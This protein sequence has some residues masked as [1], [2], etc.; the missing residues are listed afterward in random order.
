M[1]TKKTL[2]YATNENS[3]LVSP[4][5]QD[6]VPFNLQNSPQHHSP[7]PSWALPGMPVRPS[8]VPVMHIDADLLTAV[9]GPWQG[10]QGASLVPK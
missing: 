5:L 7:G 3:E 8:D 6:L 4:M 10:H 9:P 2:Q 1:M